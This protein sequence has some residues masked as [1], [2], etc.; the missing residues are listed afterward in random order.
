VEDNSYPDLQAWVVED[1]QLRLEESNAGVLAVLELAC[2]ESLKLLNQAK[3]LAEGVCNE[4][5]KMSDQ[6]IFSTQLLKAFR[7]LIIFYLSIERAVFYTEEV[8]ENESS[9]TASKYEATM[10]FST[11]G[12][13]RLRW[14]GNGAGR[15]MA[16]A[17]YELCAMTASEMQPDVLT[18]L[19]MS[20]EYVC[21]WLIRRL[22]VKPLDRNMAIGD[23][24]REYLSAIVSQGKLY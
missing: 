22:I 21:S 11:L 14:F 17:R 10:P 23:M 5:G 12:L 8:Y 2:N 3:E 6:Y 4:D 19:S 7:G 24:Y 16:M 18:S 13:K 20:S 1:E 9:H 15:L